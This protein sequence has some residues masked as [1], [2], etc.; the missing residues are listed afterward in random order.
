M[1]TAADTELEQFLADLWGRLTGA[2]I[3]DRTAHTPK[4]NRKGTRSMA[5]VDAVVLHQMAFSRGSDPTRYDTVVAHF[6]VLPDG[7]ILRLHPEAE[8]LWASNGFNG[9]SVAVEFAGN[10][11]NTK[12]RCWKPK[13]F[14]CHKVT[15]EQVAAGRSLVRHLVDTFGLKH[16]FAHRQSSA[17]RE[18]DPG[19]DLWAGV[20]QWAVDQL[21]LSD[22]GPGY[23]IGSGNPIP[24]EWRTW[25]A[26]SQEA[27]LTSGSSGTEAAMV[28][29]AIR[30]GER[31]ENALTDLVF[32]ARHPER[33]GR[34][35]A[36]GEQGFSTLSGEW[37]GIRDTLVR[38]ALSGGSA[39]APAPGAGGGIDVV[40]VRGITVARQ[41][42]PQVEQLLAAAQADGVRLGGGGFRTRAEQV[43]LRRKNCGTTEYDIYRKPS[44]QCSPMTAIP[45]TS[46][47]E[48]GLAIDFTYNGG[49]IKTHDNP[50]FRWLDA[51]AGRFG[52]RNL[53]KEPWHWSVDGK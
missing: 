9:R 10:F 16:I 35:L 44:S 38:P 1:Y 30:S 23:K 8:L 41:I 19:P 28:R 48:R 32:Y 42:A 37:L 50:G 11:P 51:N 49:S 43:A 7:K 26:T 22:G 45:G 33:G 12:G 40:E 3:V 34:P 6:A 21:K 13:E 14:G 18:N 46:N 25:G 5:K 39:P 20:G 31:N 15:P 17:T 27:E 53:P 52:L 2:A 29:S 36:G 47:H 4:A 24:V